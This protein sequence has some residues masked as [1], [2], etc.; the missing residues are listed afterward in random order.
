MPPGRGDARAAR[1][2]HARAVR[3]RDRRASSTFRSV[4]R[5]RGLVL[6]TSRPRGPYVVRR[7]RD[8]EA[9][10][11]PG[12]PGTWMSSGSASSRRT[13][14]PVRSIRR[15][16]DLIPTP[17][18]RRA[19]SP[20]G[21]GEEDAGEGIDARDRLRRGWWEARLF[22]ASDSRAGRRR[23][24]APWRIAERSVRDRARQ[25]QAIEVGRRGESEICPPLDEMRTTRPRLGRGEP[26]AAREHEAR[27]EAAAD[28]P[29][30]DV[31]RHRD[32]FRDS[33]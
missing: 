27:E 2:A 19:R 7:S 14:D 11:Y 10:A 29:S 9:C 6:E 15:M 1:A 8:G 5:D 25:D 16:Q 30:F 22:R 17:E 13:G 31:Q 3:H 18:S 24:V 20:R 28:S 33:R 26:P 23:P 21:G 32:G 12:T 4:Q